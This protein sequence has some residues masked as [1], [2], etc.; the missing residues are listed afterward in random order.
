MEGYTGAAPV[1]HAWKA[2]TFAAML[3]THLNSKDFTNHSAYFPSQ[4]G[5]SVKR[6][7]VSN[8]VP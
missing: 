3:I 2:R 1:S 8:F 4:G 5:I 6:E 7:V